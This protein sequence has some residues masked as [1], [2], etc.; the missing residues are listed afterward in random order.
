[1]LCKRSIQ[2]HL[3]YSNSLKRKC[4]LIDNGKKV[5][6]WLP[7]SR[8]K[9]MTAKGQEERSGFYLLIVLLRCIVGQN[10]QLYTCSE[11]TSLYENYTP[12]RVGIFKKI[13]LKINFIWES[14]RFW[15]NAASVVFSPDGIFTRF[16]EATGK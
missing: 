12:Q 10:S 3:A 1:M 15:C 16:E 6:Q 9:G 2:P 5:H 13:R 11:Y 8:V 7:G 14:S 4:Q